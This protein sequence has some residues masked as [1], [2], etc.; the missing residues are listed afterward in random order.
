MCIHCVLYDLNKNKSN[1]YCRAYRITNNDN[2]ADLLKKIIM[3][4]LNVVLQ[5]I[6]AICLL[7]FEQYLESALE[8]ISINIGENK[9]IFSNVEILYCTYVGDTVSCKFYLQ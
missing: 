6:Y 1:S 8:P 2:F 3:H 4:F 5:Y 9:W 7:K